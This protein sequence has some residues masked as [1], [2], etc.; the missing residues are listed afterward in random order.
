[1][2]HQKILGATVTRYDC[3]WPRATSYGVKHVTSCALTQC[4]HNRMHNTGT[5]KSLIYNVFV[6]YCAYCVYCAGFRRIYTFMFG[7]H[8]LSERGIR[9]SKSASILL[10]LGTI[11]TIPDIHP[12]M[13]SKSLSS[14]GFPSCK[15]GFLLCTLCAQCRKYCAQYAAYA[16]MVSL[17]YQLEATQCPS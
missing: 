2:A 9:Q 15:V 3:T 10:K 16:V 14:L 7:T 5:C 1:M 8:T 17:T 12:V 13:R 4:K 11:G 6:L